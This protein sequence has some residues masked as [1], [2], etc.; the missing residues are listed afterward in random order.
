MSP[1]LDCTEEFASG[2]E[3]SCPVPY[4][5]TQFVPF[6]SHAQYPSN[7][8]SRKLTRHFLGDSDVDLSPIFEKSLLLLEVYYEDKAVDT[9][10]QYEAYNFFGFLCDLGGAIGLWLG[11]SLLT[12]L[13][14]VE[15]V[16]HTMFVAGDVSK[17]K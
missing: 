17:V 8:Y 7:F 5:V 14:I 12:F 15:H 6:V 9:S 16:Y 4:V 2:E 10:V 11:G 1:L 13:E 3:C